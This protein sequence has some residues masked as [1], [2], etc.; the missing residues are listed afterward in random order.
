VGDIE[1]ALLIMLAMVGVTLLIGCVNLANLMLARG[2]ARANEIALRTALGAPRA[3]IVR[4]ILTESVVLGLLGGVL[5]IAISAWGVDVIIALSAGTLPRVE[6]IRLDARVL[7]FGFALALVTGALFGLL[8]ALRAS[9]GDALGQL[10]GSRGA[11]GRGFRVRNLLVVAEVGLALLLVIAA[12]LMARSFAA[13]GRVSPGFDPN[14]V[15]T[16]TMM[17]NVAGAED[18]VGHIVQRRREFIERIGALPGVVAAGAANNLP[19]QGGV[20]E[21]FEFTRADGTAAPDGS[22]L[23]ADRTYIDGAYLRAM[24]IPLLR[25]ELLPQDRPQVAPDAPTPILVSES[26]ARQFWPGTDAVGQVVRS[27]RF[28]AVVAGVVGDVRHLSLAKTP[29]PAVYFPHFAGPRVITTIVART[30]GDPAALSGAVREIVRQVDPNQ[31]VR[32][33]APLSTVM[34]ESLARDRFFT[35]LFA[36]FGL[37]ALTLAAIGVYGVIA[38]AVGQ[39][40]QEI[41]VRIAL[42]A[43]AADILGMVMRDGMRPVLAGVVLGIIAAVLLTRVLANQLYGVS[44]TDPLT[45]ALAPTA[46]A[47][48]ALVACYVPARRAVRV[49][50]ISALR[51]E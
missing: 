35:V 6:D 1:T 4:Q 30:E 40:T 31:P 23:R 41:G 45:F 21:W 34:S 51:D 43:H 38:Y 8:P 29:P 13:L 28:T 7:A 22:L 37:L 32:T 47:V 24:G 16:V 46:L 48:V 9:R 26:A 33:I 39:R 5:G 36:I 42:G 12:G 49:E 3:R 15:L 19:L 11:L 25:G 18:V 14:Q 17:I 27:G 44:T 20:W 50:P 10:R 2:P